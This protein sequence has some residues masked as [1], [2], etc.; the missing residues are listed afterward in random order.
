MISAGNRWSTERERA[1][2]VISPDY[3]ASA[4]PT[5]LRAGNLMVPLAAKPGIEKERAIGL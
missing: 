5:T 1:A 2:F 4:I 3:R